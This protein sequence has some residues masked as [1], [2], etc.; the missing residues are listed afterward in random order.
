MAHLGS[1][2]EFHCLP[3]RAHDVQSLLH[4]WVCV[5]CLEAP[6]SPLQGLQFGPVG[7]LHVTLVGVEFRGLD[8]VSLDV[9]AGRAC[10]EG[11]HGRGAA[12]DTDV[13]EEGYELLVVLSEYLREFYAALD[14]SVP[15][16]GL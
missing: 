4:V 9:L 6:H 8:A 7:G 3:H 11:G 15:T 1:N 10:Q 2:F 5:L 14:A 12:A 13:L 16:L